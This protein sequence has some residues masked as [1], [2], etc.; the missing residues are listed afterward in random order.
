M[1]D[2]LFLLDSISAQNHLLLAEFLVDL[3]H[4]IDLVLSQLK[5]VQDLFDVLALDCVLVA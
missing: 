1:V 5:L 2:H 4:G 3:S